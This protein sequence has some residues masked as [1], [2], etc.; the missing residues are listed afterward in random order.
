MTKIGYLGELSGIPII[1]SEHCL[2]DDKPGCIPMG[3]NKLP[4]TNKD[5]PVAYLVA[6]PKYLK[7]L[8]KNIN[9]EHWEVSDDIRQNCRKTKT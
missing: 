4:V 1:S 8:V 7:E 9:S 3:E 6:H 2:I 5:A